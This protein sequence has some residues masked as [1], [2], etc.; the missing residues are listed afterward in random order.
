MPH[1]K[2]F[3]L[4]KGLTRAHGRYTVQ[5]RDAKK[6]KVEGK[7]STVQN[8]LTEI[9][10]YNHLAGKQGIGVVP[11]NDDNKCS[12]AAI[13]IDVYDLDFNDLEAKLNKLK[14][15]LV[16]CRTKSG[17]AHLYLFLVEPT[18]AI[19]VR[20][21]VTQ[22]AVALGFPGVEVFPK[23]DYLACPEDVGNW[24]NMPYFDSER[25]TRYCIKDGKALDVNQFIDL[26]YSERI[27]LEDTDGE[28]ISIKIYIY[29]HKCV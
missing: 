3:E 1:K 12:F 21:R 4:F 23:Q 17:G 27:L 24:I 5:G 15:P 2:L 8:E 22:W 26:A 10:W 29:H 19:D 6:N 25:T 9:E 20:D 11:I 7:A 18:P 16:I 13:D 28:E 14:L